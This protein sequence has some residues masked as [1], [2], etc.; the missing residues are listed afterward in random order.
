MNHVAGFLDWYEFESIE[1]NRARAVEDVRIPIL[2]CSHTSNRLVYR[3][4]S[5]LETLSR[6]RWRWRWRKH[7]VKD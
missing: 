4:I 5:K 6:L 2:T 1:T 3:N 7:W